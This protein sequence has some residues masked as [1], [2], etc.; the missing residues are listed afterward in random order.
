[1]DHL[2]ACERGVCVPGGG[3][4]IATSDVAAISRP[5]GPEGQT[6]VG[7]TLALA[8]DPLQFLGPCLRDYGDIFFLRVRWLDMYVVCGQQGPDDVF[9]R[10]PDSFTLDR[11]PRGL[12]D[13]LG[14]SLLA[15]EGAAWRRQRG[16]LLPAFRQEQMAYYANT[17]QT[18]TQRELAMWPGFGFVDVSERMTDLALAIVVQTVL[19]VESAIDR[20]GVSLALRELMKQVRG[21]LGTGVRV[22][23]RFPTPGNL[24]ARNALADIDH[25]LQEV[26]LTDDG[27]RA[28]G[29]LGLLRRAAGSGSIDDRQ[30]RDE[31]L[32]MLL[33]G[34]ETVALA[35]AYACWLLG[36]DEDLQESLFDDVQVLAEQSQAP[37]QRT[38]ESPLLT[39]VVKE[40]LRLFP[41]VW[42]MGREVAEPVEVASY[43]LKVGAQVLIPIW[44]NQRR[45]DWYVHSDWFCP[46]R[47]LTGETND[48]PSYAFFPFGAGMR[49]CLGERLAYQEIGL[50]VAAIVSRFRISCLGSTMSVVPTVT[51]R[52]RSPVPILVERR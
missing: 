18:L 4:V 20:D 21:I 40:V 41:P 8:K 29:V 7:H 51:L 39:A 49:S 42:A 37:Q 13:A 27:V 22:P 6:L 3:S 24:R 44:V 32:T 25:V 17:I 10:R 33:V 46:E 31:L 15:M 23:G 9:V 26:L 16:T 36:G 1:M 34:H 12:R 2:L 52:P 47:W 38:Q 30:I 35:A 14:D 19:G 43:P 48:L 11:L 50:M 28:D 45:P 5:P